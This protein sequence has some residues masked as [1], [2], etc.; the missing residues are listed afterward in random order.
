MVTYAFDSDVGSSV[1]RDHYIPISR[2]S[3]TDV[4]RTVPCSYPGQETEQNA[5]MASSD[6]APPLPQYSDLRRQRIDTTNRDTFTDMV[7]P[8]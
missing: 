1:G 3:D 5:E 8:E 4:V 7:K 6:L 2:L